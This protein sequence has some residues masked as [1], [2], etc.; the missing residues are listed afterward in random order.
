MAG[1]IEAELRLVPVGGA[2]GGA[3]QA[4]T[5]FDTLVAARTTSTFLPAIARALGFGV[6]GIGAVLAAP[7]VSALLPALGVAGIGYAAGRIGEE[8]GEGIMEAVNEGLEQR[9]AQRA[10]GELTDAVEN[11]QRALE[12]LEAAGLLGAEGLQQLEDGTIALYDEFGNVV[13]VFGEK[14]TIFGTVVDSVT[15]TLD[16][17]A[18]TVGQA[19]VDLIGDSGK[20]GQAFSDLVARL[21]RGD[22][23]TSKEERSYTARTSQLQTQSQANFTS[24]DGR[25]TYVPPPS[26]LQ[27]SPLFQSPTNLLLRRNTYTR[28]AS[29]Q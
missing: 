8:Q 13:Q 18:S 6:G 1:V 24:F 5:D 28:G 11:N 21:E 29:S 12:E 2:I 10:Q 27:S 15:N 9:R 3:G 20:L 23:L 7:L 25:A 14:Q 4:G 17:G 26:S 22:G 16:A 19:F